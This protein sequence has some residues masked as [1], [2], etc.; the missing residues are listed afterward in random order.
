MPTRVAMNISRNERLA[1][2]LQVSTPS[3]VGKDVVTPLAARIRGRT[4]AR[5]GRKVTIRPCD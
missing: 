2:G 4:K 3:S 1:K 5:L